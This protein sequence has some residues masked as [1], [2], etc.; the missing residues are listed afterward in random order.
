MNRKLS[1]YQNKNILFVSRL[2]PKKGVDILIN[3][4]INI[5]N[6]DWQLTIVGPSEKSYL[7][8]LH[9]LVS[10]QKYSGKILFLG[11]LDKNEINKLYKTSSFFALATHSENFGFV[12]AEALGC[13]LPVLT[14]T[15]APW[16]EI[17][18]YYC[19]HCVENTQSVFE[20]Y[21]KKMMSYSPEELKTMGDNG[22]KLIDEKYSWRYTS[23]N[24][25]NKYKELL[26]SV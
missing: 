16:E 3:A 1:S 24:I 6:N 2:S 20:K 8:S 7:K 13:K 15:N 10:S 21:M 26:I 4:F 19:G 11:P 18:E 17:N 12:I 23:R 25:I 22:Y 5:A 9:T 14:S